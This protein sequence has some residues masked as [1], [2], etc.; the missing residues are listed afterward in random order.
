MTTSD[1]ILWAVLSGPLVYL[2][3]IL[4]S[5]AP[6]TS[7]EYHY[8]NRKL[9]AH[10]YVDTT[11]MYALQVAAVALFA[12]WGYMYGIMAAVV[13]VFWGIGYLIIAWLIDSGHLDEFIES[14]SFGTLHQFIAHGGKFRLV[15]AV[16]AVLTLVA[17]SGPAMFEAFF[18][19]SVIERA[20]KDVPGFSTTA[21]AILFLGFS[22]IYMLRGGFAGAVRLDRIQLATGY[23]GF[24]LLVSLS[25]YSIL[26]RQHDGIVAA[27]ALLLTGCSTAI[28][29]GRIS[30]SRSVGRNDPFAFVCTG[31]AL[32]PPIVVLFLSISSEN[33]SFDNI[34]FEKYFFPDTFSWLAILS[35]FVA[36]ALYQ[37][38]DVGQWQRLLS[39]DPHARSLVESRTL[40]STSIRNVALTSPI[41]W[42]I[43]IVFGILLKVI[44][45]EANAYEASYLLVDHILGVPG[46]LKLWLL[47][48]LIVSLVAIM[49]S[50]I[51]ALIS[52]TS[53][54]V[55]NDIFHRKIR[56]QYDVAIDRWATLGTL[57]L[58]LFFYLF[59]KKLAQ[60]KTDAVLYLCWSF[61]IGFTPAVLFAILKRDI[62]ESVLILSLLAG[63]VGAAAPLALLGPDAIYEY[64]PWCALLGAGVIGIFGILPRKIAIK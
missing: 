50:T 13:P 14:D 32:I 41:T 35:L 44:S 42:V 7:R 57:A 18:T 49:F 63:V 40:I 16:G 10:E 25:L 5:P 39:V 30:H 29:V 53:F 24:V 9:L 20:S 48:A 12:T 38:V 15:S 23:F 37:L 1:V 34:Q 47:G 56:S 61:Q 8:A 46:Q 3:A 33:A 22:A 17:I 60:D 26:G 59:V 2:V 51:D 54:T 28:F 45:P 52:A 55:T 21:L 58:Q 36:N 43:A 19:A 6:T 62:P 31:A 64:S 11:I 27:L 4:F